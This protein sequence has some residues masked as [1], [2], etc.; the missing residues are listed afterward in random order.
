SPARAGS[1][2]AGRARDPRAADPGGGD[3]RLRLGSPGVG[4]S[5][6]RLMRTIALLLSTAVASAAQAGAGGGHTF[7][8]ARHC[9]AW[10][11]ALVLARARK[12][13]CTISVPYAP[14][15]WSDRIDEAMR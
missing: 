15:A 7:V 6:C 13:Q 10:A 9:P 4:T 14:S 11:R 12:C 2:G 8:A 3:R 1:D 5:G